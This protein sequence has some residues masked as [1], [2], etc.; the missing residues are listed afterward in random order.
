MKSHTDILFTR[1][2]R[3][4]KDDIKELLVGGL[5]VSTDD[6]T[7]KNKQDLILMCS[8]ELRSAAGSS[9]VNI[10]R[11]DHEFPYKQILID[12]ADKLAP[13]HT[14]LSWTQYKIED[15]HTAGEIERAIANLFEERTKLWWSKLSDEK[16]TEFVNGIN[17]AMGRAEKVREVTNEGVIKSFI[18]QQMIEN[19]IQAGIMSGLL[20]VS[21]G[22]V[23]G[24]LGLS[25]IAQLG[26]LIVLQ[27]VGWMGGIKFALFG[28]AGHGAMGGAVAGI[29]G[30]AVGS[31]LAIP[32][33]FAFADGAA[34]RKTV[35]T[36]VLL[37]AK[38]RL[39][40]STH[41]IETC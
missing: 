36:V 34:Y 8:K 26:W 30:L 2:S 28:I 3:L 12:V 29:G 10:F 39:A 32:T 41:T 24:T 22:G 4:K 17:T 7:N 27:T 23:L 11:K 16:K 40:G 25:V 6:V 33:L 19:I 31:A 1:L 37:I 18:T 9:T 21:A 13:G 35:P 38:N 5:K 14:I 20:K 15:S